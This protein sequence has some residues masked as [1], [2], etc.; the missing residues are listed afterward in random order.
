MP[1]YQL[2]IEEKPSAELK[3]V[4]TNT[5]FVE[6][7]PLVLELGIAGP[8]G[9][10]GPA[11]AG[12]DGSITWEDPHM[13]ALLATSLA[14]GSTAD[15]DADPITLGKLGK[16]AQL[17]VGSSVPLRIDVQTVNGSRSTVTTIYTYNGQTREWRPPDPVFVQVDGDGSAHFG[18]TVT[19]LST[20]QT[21]DARATLYWDEV[22]P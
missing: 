3:F 14:P 12:G 7:D 16:L 6:S 8:Q 5:Y 13:E 2:V 20:W 10:R 18:V 17:D 15:L 22:D 1:E 4:E 21:A 19:N 11:G 9:P